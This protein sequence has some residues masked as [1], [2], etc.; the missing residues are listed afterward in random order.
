MHVIIVFPVFFAHSEGRFRIVSKKL[1]RKS[2]TFALLI[3]Q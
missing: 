1:S 2:V 3:C